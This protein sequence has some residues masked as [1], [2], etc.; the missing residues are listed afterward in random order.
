MASAS[1][2]SSWLTDSMSQTAAV[3]DVTSRTGRDGPRHRQRT[4]WSSLRRH[5][6]T[7]LAPSPRVPRLSVGAPARPIRWLPHDLQSAAHGVT[8]WRRSRTTGRCSTRGSPSP[9]SAQPPRTDAAVPDELER[10]RGPGRRARGVRTEVVPRR[11]RPRRRRPPTPPT[12]T[13]ACTCSP[14]ASSQPNTINLDGVFGALANVVWTSAGPCAV[15]GFERTR[16]RLRAR[17]P[18]QVLR[19]RQVPADDRL[20][21]AAGRAHR[22]RRPRAARG[23][24]LAGHHRHA[25]GL[26]Q[27]QRRHPRHLDGRGPHRA[28]RR[29]RRRLRHRRRRLDHGHPVRRRHGTRQ[30][31]R[32]LSGR[33]QRRHR[34]RPRRRLRR[35]GR[36]LRHGR[37]Q[38]DDARRHRRQGQGAVGRRATSSSSATA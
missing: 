30:H 34:H 14:T 9:R 37:H 12:P 18:V 26:L 10:A 15:E 25:R 19:R 36:A 33:S 5:D 23:A 32:A 7:R 1:A 31:R 21:R 35:R 16:L 6:G 11:D 28:G 38:G 13:C 24:P 2:A 4:R 8:D 17:G 20:R 3:S 29:R 27:L 22:R